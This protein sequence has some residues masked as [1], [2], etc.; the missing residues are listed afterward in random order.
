MLR[1]RAREE[2]PAAG[3]WAWPDE[4]DGGQAVSAQVDR[5]VRAPARDAGC[6]GRVGGRWREGARA[7]SPGRRTSSLA[8]VPA[9][10]GR[11]HSQGDTMKSLKK[12]SRLRIPANRFLEA[13]EIIKGW[14]W[15][16]WE[17]RRTRQGLGFLDGIRDTGPGG[18]G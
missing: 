14:R 12:E 11:A 6:H 4:K 7:G 13:A 16:P 5:W 1:I 10:Q 17:L 2:R 18:R 15:L 3:A 9:A 8:Q